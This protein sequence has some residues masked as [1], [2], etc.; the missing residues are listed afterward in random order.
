MNFLAVHT[1]AVCLRPRP[2]ECR[3]THSGSTA[4]QLVATGALEVAGGPV[5]VPVAVALHV[6]V[7][8]GRQ[9]ATAAHCRWAEGHS[10]G[11]VRSFQQR[12]FCFTTPNECLSGKFYFKA[13]IYSNS[14]PIIWNT[15]V[16]STLRGRFM[17]T[18][19]LSF[20]QTYGRS[21][22]ESALAGVFPGGRKQRG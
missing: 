22:K 4:L 10:F 8:G 14:S 19:F 7:V 18:V 11:P 6:A 13:A 5:V 15:G 3:L 17:A 9:S 20:F 1:C 16:P 2:G 21:N 12:N